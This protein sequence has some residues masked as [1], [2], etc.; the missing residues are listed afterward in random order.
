M[1]RLRVAID[2]DGEIQENSLG[3]YTQ[4]HL[5]ESFADSTICELGT[6][7]IPKDYETG[8]YKAVQVRD[9]WT[10]KKKS[11]EAIKAVDDARKLA[12]QT[13]FTAELLA[14][15]ADEVG[16]HPSLSVLI[17]HAQG[18]YGV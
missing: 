17:R 12:R 15:D 8:H 18:R 1:S 5:E 6:H 13:P 14:L 9:V 4:E 2:D 7:T 11:R 3:F 16:I 10:F